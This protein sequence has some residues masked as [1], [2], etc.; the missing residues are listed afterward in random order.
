MV[1]GEGDG[2]VFVRGWVVPGVLLGVGAVGRVVELGWLRDG[3]DEAGV[4]TAA[5]MAVCGIAI[6]VIAL[7][8]GVVLAGQVFG[9]EMDPPGAIARKL[10][11][12]AVFAAAVAVACASIDKDPYQMRGAVLA[13]HAV[14][15]VYFVGVC[16]L[17]KMDLLEG[18]VATVIAMAVQVGLFVAIAQALPR[19]TARLM[20]F[21]G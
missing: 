2:G 19:A 7:G 20:F 11:G 1:D 16:W 4:G 5:F 8:M 21:G 10:V 9:S 15:L 13:L 14:L 12:L 3:R 6:G 18:L 17:M